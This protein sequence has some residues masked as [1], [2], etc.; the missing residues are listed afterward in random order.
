MLGLW[1]TSRTSLFSN[2]LCWASS[3][4]LNRTTKSAIAVVVVVV[5]AF[6]DVGIDDV[7]VVVGAAIWFVNFI[8]W[9]Y[10][11]KKMSSQG[12]PHTHSHSV[13]FYLRIGSSKLPGSFTFSLYILLY[14]FLVV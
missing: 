8:V 12:L 2:S 1:E 4:S 5:V 3:S 13:L 14:N 11:R 7:A 10:L 6:V 9:L